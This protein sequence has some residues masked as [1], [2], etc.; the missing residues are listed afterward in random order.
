[1]KKRRRSVLDELATQAAITIEQATEVLG[2]GRTAAYE[3]AR[4]GEFPDAEA[5]RRVVVPVPPCSSGWGSR[6]EGHIHKRV[7]KNAA[8]KE[9]ARW[10]V[11]V[12]VGV[13]DDGRRKQ[14][15]HGGFDKRP[16]A[17]V[18]RAKIVNDLHSGTYVAPDRLTLA[19]W[20]RDSW[21]SMICTRIKPSDARLLPASYTPSGKL[22]R[23]VAEALALPHDYFP[24][25]RQAVV[26]ERIRADSR[27]RQRLYAELK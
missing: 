24:E 2:L 10:Y 5:E 20:V 18:E 15:W 26:L 16:E 7:R 9:T 6:S 12:D 27:I 21:P 23:K 14:R 19:E 25:Y 8:G 11:V 1:M 17:E 22:T 3:A 4:R 13:D